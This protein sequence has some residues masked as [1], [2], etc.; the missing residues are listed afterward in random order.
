MRHDDLRAVEDDQITQTVGHV[1]YLKFGEVV[2]PSAGSLALHP[3]V[4][5]SHLANPGFVS[6]RSVEEH[7]VVVGSFVSWHHIPF[8]GRELVIG[9]LIRDSVN[10]A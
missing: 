4:T 1:E 3:Q 10:V 9:Q 7:L 5:P 6:P 2:H 8:G